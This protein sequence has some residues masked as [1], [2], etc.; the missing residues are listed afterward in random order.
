MDDTKTSKV[1]VN[2]PKIN[3]WKRE[4]KGEVFIKVINFPIPEDCE[5]G[6]E[7]MWVKKTSGTDNDGSG[8]LAN[9]PVLCEEVSFG[10]LVK[11]AG[12]TD[13]L[14]PS[15]IERMNTDNE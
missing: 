10:D 3:D 9:T 2:M 6:G 12:G 5:F 7:S 13:T 8:T 1:E 11:Y 14:K 4:S 15:F